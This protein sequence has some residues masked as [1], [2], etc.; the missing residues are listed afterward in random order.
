ML[1]KIFKTQ[2]IKIAVL[3]LISLFLLI[4]GITFLKGKNI[5]KKQFTYY[6]VFD[7]AAGLM[8]A[9]SVIINGVTVG[10][11]EK[12]ALYGTDNNKVLVTFTINK[13]VSIPT[14]S[15]VQI[16][17]PG[18]IGAMQLECILGNATTYF[19]E[20]DTLMGYVKPSLLSGVDNIKN[21][22][23]TVTFVLK[24]LLQSGEI[25]SSITNINSATNRLD[26]IIRSGEIE[27]ILSDVENLTNT[28]KNNDSKIDSIIT[29][30]NKFSGSLKNTDIPKTLEEISKGL[31][32]L[33]SVLSNI[34]NGKGT[35]G[36]LT[37]NDTLYQNLD[38]TIINLD[39]LI[40]DMKAN[41]KKYINVTI[42]GGK[43]K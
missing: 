10:I 41:P 12:V 11:V 5:F 19:N 15:E 18:I 24:N 6:A 20:G 29:N 42:F 37:T 13:K 3:S 17:S 26:S 30:V 8:P 2:E 32:Q 21:N 38:K 31:K 23:D 14:N 28:I 16:V 35:L 1:K 39:D 4:W 9:N 27:D 7:Q 33:E 22:L 34:E 36:Q 40:K 43:K 25:Q